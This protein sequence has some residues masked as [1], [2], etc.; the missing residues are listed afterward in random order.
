MAPYG[1]PAACFVQSQV[2][3]TRHRF[4]RASED[5]SPHTAQVAVE[6]KSDVQIR[7][8]RLDRQILAMFDSIRASFSNL[9]LILQRVYPVGN[10]APQHLVTWPVLMI[11]FPIASSDT[12]YIVRILKAIRHC[13]G[14]V[15]SSQKPSVPASFHSRA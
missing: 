12:V 7:S 2:N 10:I 3:Y 1:K 8:E 6:G 9:R 5:F 14:P 4:F 13:P 11:I 15:W